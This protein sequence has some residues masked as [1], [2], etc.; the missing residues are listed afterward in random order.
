MWQ[1]VATRYKEL[2]GETAVRD[3][4]DIK[5]KFYSL[6]KFGK[7]Q[8]TGT[9]TKKYQQIRALRIYKDNLRKENFGNAGSVED[10]EDQEEGEEQEDEVDDDFAEEESS[11]NNPMNESFDSNRDN[12]DMGIRLD[13]TIS[14]LEETQAPQGFDHRRSRSSGS[15]VASSTHS[16]SSVVKSKNSRPIG[17]K[18]SGRETAASAMNAM[19]EV[20]REANLQRQQQEMNRQQQEMHQRNGICIANRCT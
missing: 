18:P 5:R 13:D 7:G 10:A 20:M 9:K 14:V 3:P 19:V 1:T 11:E 16:S 4:N 6:N 15:S 12:G 8:P 17:G 2:S